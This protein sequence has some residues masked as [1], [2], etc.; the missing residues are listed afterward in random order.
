MRSS[1]FELQ[2]HDTFKAG[3]WGHVS[4]FQ[5]SSSF[6]PAGKTFLCPSNSSCVLTWY[7]GYS[8]NALTN[9]SRS[10]EVM[11]R[12][13]EAAAAAAS[14]L[15]EQLA[16]QQLAAKQALKQVSCLRGSTMLCLHVVEKF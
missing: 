1:L 5:K 11:N 6:M 12:E 10:A 16:V 3:C 7:L 15:T 2:C 4:Q 9:F 14:Q 13:H 8:G